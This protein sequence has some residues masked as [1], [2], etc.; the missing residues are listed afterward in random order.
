MLPRWAPTLCTS[1]CCASLSLSL[2]LGSLGCASTVSRLDGDFAAP[3]GPA[4]TD[5]EKQDWLVVAPTRAELFDSEGRREVRDD[6]FGLYQVGARDPESIP[7]LADELGGSFG[8]FDRHREVVQPYDRKRV[9]AG[10]LGA[11]GLVALGIGTFLF[12][13]SFSSDA[14]GDNGLEED[15]SVDTSQAALGGVLVGVGFGLGIAGIA[16]SPGQAERSRAEAARYAFLP[17]DDSREAISGAVARRNQRI[18]ERCGRAAA[19]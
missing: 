5:C 19:P 1:V 13:S 9:L 15:Q 6:G 18:R 3:A 4:R 7:S 10:S 2:F 14:G 17:P 12:V 16:V 11:A 8:S